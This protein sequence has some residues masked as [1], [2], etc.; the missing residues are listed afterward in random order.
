MPNFIRDWLSLAL[1]WFTTISCFKIMDERLPYI[2][3]D[4]LR[5]YW[6]MASPFI[7]CFF[8]LK[9]WYRFF[10]WRRMMAIGP[11]P[12]SLARG[13]GHQVKEVKK[14]SLLEDG[15]ILLAL[16]GMA[17]IFKLFSIPHFWW[18]ANSIMIG[19]VILKFIFKRL[20]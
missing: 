7:L 3:N 1:I 2:P 20:G 11:N 5:F 12:M 13:E 14:P 16:F 17:T 10:K 18:W 9:Y 6:Y 15:C 4:D 8:S 19:L